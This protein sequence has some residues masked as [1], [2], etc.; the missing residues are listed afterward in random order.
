MP[1]AVVFDFDGVIADTEKLHYRSALAVVEGDGIAF[2]WQEYLDDFLGFD[3]R[4]LFRY[5]FAR[6]GKHVEPAKLRA[7]VDAK[8]R[9][10]VE[11]VEEEG[12]E[13]FPGAVELICL[14]SGTVPLALCSGAL[15]S[16]VEPILRRLRL[17]DCFAAAV[18]A[19]DTE[20]SKPDPAPYALSLERLRL[21]MPGRAFEASRCVAIED[22]PTGIRAA[23]AA[24]LRVLAVAHS[25]G[26][27][28]LSEA[29]RVVDSLAGVT[30]E[31]LDELTAS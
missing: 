13:A 27:F 17:S 14:L 16:D 23:R 19:E 25:Y 7:L 24:G 15:R 3:D 12:V 8:A 31:L 29:T 21:A 22:T 11:I 1:E 28:Q 5:V 6:Q 30:L 2:T 4:D 20:R 18:T 10:F 9:A 26:R